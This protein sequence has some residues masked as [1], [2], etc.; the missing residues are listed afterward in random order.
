MNQFPHKKNLTSDNPELRSEPIFQSIF[1]DKW[2]EL[3]PVMHKHYLNR[4]YSDDVNTVEG[5]LDVMCV[6]PLRLLS[7]LFW[8][9]GGIPPHNEKNVPVT[10][11]FESSKDTKEFTFNRV[12]HFKNRKPYQFQ[13]RMIQVAG[14]EV[15][16]IMRFGIGWRMSVHWEDD[17]TKL[18][19]KGYAVKL[20]GHF[21]SIPLTMLIGEGNAWEKAVDENSFDMQVDIAHP[22]WGKI[23]EYKGRFNIRGKV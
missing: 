18:K 22:W 9:L 4:P 21:I 13:S 3:P 14:N 17:C 10:V 7:P 2:K 12:F 11:R 5:T 15:I 16:E 19:H 8:F 23:Y 20:F 6:G 1:G